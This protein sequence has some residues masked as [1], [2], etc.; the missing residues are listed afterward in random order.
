MRIK[1]AFAAMM[2]GHP[3]GMV[4]TADALHQLHIGRIVILLAQQGLE[5]LH[6]G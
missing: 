3:D 4:I 5:F 6:M 1:G 2:V